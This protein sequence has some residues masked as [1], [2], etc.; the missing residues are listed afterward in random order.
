MTRRDAEELS[1]E[2]LAA[3]ERLRRRAPCDEDRL[4]AGD[5]GHVRELERRGLVALG[6]SMTATVRRYARTARP[7]LK[8]LK[9]YRLTP[10]GRRA[11]E[12][13]AGGKA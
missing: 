1:E 2:L 8:V 7:P 13:R 3:L 12:G 5:A 9:Q 11:L 6:Q 4:P 10:A